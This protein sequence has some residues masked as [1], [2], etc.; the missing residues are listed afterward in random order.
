M[1]VI[2]SHDRIRAGRGNHV[3][4]ARAPPRG[5]PTFDI[6]SS[7]V[8]SEIGASALVP[9]GGSIPQVTARERRSNRRVWTGYGI[10]G[11]LLLAYVVS[12]LA[13]R[14][15][16]QWLWL[17]GWSVAGFEMAA[18]IGCLY[19][20]RAKRPGRVVPLILGAG[21]LSWS[22]GDFVLSWESLGGHTRPLPQAP[23]SSTSSSIPSPTSR[24]SCRYR[25]ASGA[26]LGR[27]GSTV[28]SPDSARPPYAGRSP[29]TASITSPVGRR[30]VPR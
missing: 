30:S 14:P 28:S 9:P 3:R 7:V 22:L 27:T 20:G 13:R 24:R 10:L 11:V 25:S 15:N 12:L 19:R 5:A 6:V 16:Q 23:T 4:D 18:S 26:W 29:S 8:D 21:L 2:L 1:S 17:N